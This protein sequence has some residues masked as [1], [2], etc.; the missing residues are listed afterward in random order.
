MSLVLP[1]SAC[2]E[3]LMPRVRAIETLGGTFDLGFALVR[4]EIR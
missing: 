4:G 1:V 2:E 3:L